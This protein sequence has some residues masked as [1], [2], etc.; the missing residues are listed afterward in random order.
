MSRQASHVRTD[1]GGRARPA[2]RP[3]DEQPPR[4]GRPD[5]RLV[6]ITDRDQAAPRT[7]EAVVRE[8]LEAGAPA[9][10]LRDKAATARQ[11]FDQAI[12]LRALTREFGAL[13]FINDR[14][15]VALACDA[16][17]VHLGPDDI[18]VAAL[19]RV[20][21]RPFLIGTSTDDPGAAA[22]AEAD[23]ADYIGCGAVFGTR[24]KAGLEQERIGPEG[25]AAVARA[26]RIPVIAIGGITPD[27]AAALADTGVA[28]I[29]VIGA[30]MAADDPRAAVARLLGLR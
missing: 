24:S 3:V 5:L 23:G 26:V 13:L 11:L 12:A 19:R 7:V 22:R 30:V 1:T 25:A 20:V 21:P 29:A 28:G 15:D 6:V 8:C 18:P 2:N 10:Q 27:N 4:R 16:D 9:V 17:G 14:V